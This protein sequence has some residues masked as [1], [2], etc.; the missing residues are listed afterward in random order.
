M[1]KDTFIGTV[2]R[3]EISLDHRG[4]TPYRLRRA[5]G[6][7][8]AV[9]EHNDAV[10]DVHHH[11]HIVLDQRD[12][13]ATFVVHV[14][15]E[16]AHVLLLLD[17]HPRHRLIQQQQIRLRRL[18]RKLYLK[19]KAEPDFR[20]YLLYNKV[21]RE[22]ILCHVYDL[23]RSHKGAPGVDG[24]TFEMIET[25]GL[26]EWSSDIRKDLIEKT[27]QPA[28][29]AAGDDPKARG[30]GDRPL[31]IPTIRGTPTATARSGVVQM[32]SRNYLFL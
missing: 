11:A 19:A 4:V 3:A 7:L 26:E 6:D 27:Y 2:R 20:F 10:R 31:G 13:G 21:Y 29:G 22:D 15:D 32:R 17:V 8:A 1:T 25:D 9:V 23:A 16:A 12:R 5:V 28:P 14:Q 18:Q 30:N 24:F